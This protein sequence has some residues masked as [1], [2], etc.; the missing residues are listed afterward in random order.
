MRNPR[1]YHS[2]NFGIMVHRDYQNDGV[3]TG[4]MKAVLDLADNWLMLVR[5]ELTVF[6]ENERAIHLFMKR[7][8]LRSR[9]KSAWPQSETA[10]TRT[11]T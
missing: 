3:G 8:A 11:N 4:L 6:C 9:A 5:I 7:R 10:N 2:A 1:L